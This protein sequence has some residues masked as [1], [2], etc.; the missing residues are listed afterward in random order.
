MEKVYCCK[1]FFWGDIL[2]SLTL[3]KPFSQPHL[4]DSSLKAD[5][6]KTRVTQGAGGG[7]HGGE[8][9]SDLKNSGCPEF[10]LREK[11]SRQRGDSSRSL[12]GFGV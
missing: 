5:P 8:Q 4:H 12:F 10:G 6:F 2:G 3:G 9:D 11:N 1:G 7:G